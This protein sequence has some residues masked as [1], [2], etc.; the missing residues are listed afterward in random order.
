[1]TVGVTLGTIPI[2]NVV[3]T[4]TKTSTININRD[5]PRDLIKLVHQFK[6]KK[7]KKNKNSSWCS[8]SIYSL[9]KFYVCVTISI[10][11]FNIW[12]ESYTLR[13][14]PVRAFRTAMFSTNNLHA[15]E[16]SNLYLI[17]SFGWFQG[18][19]GEVEF[20]F[21]HWKPCLRDVLFCFLEKLT[22]YVKA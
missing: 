18:C 13:K 21:V 1:M 11:Y 14:P 7:K 16:F 15:G 22:L 10:L 3:A 9:R 5:L 4:S 2:H 6:L 17:F 20:I 12:N 19:I 8:H